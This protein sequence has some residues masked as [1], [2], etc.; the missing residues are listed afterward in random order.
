MRSP[1]SG[2]LSLPHEPLSPPLSISP[3][4]SP[5]SHH[6]L[7]LLHTPPSAVSPSLVSP[8]SAIGSTLSD[9]SP[10]SGGWTYPLPTQTGGYAATPLT[11]IHGLPQG[12]PTAPGL[13]M[14]AGY[15]YP[16]VSPRHAPPR[17]VSGRVTRGKAAAVAKQKG[18]SATKHEK[19]DDDDDSDLDDIGSPAPRSSGGLG[20]V[21]QE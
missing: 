7:A 20:L 3:P 15:P 9:V 5:G 4:E 14:V 18:D 2:R 21:P 11:S 12:S 16:S 1:K 6:Q 19:F 13:A 10:D 8:A 17:R